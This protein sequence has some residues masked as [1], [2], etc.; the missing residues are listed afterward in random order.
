MTISEFNLTKRETEVVE[1]VIDGQTNQQ[2]SEDLYISEHTVKDHI[3]HIMQK[4]GVRNR[5]S[6][7]RK[8]Y[9]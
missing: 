7:I 3:R 1:N 6:I 4:M 9:A 2:I 8:V 5:T